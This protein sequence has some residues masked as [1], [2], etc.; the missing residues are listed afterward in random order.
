MLKAD[1]ESKSQRRDDEYEG[2]KRF[3][4]VSK[5]DEFKFD[6]PESLTKCKNDYFNKYVPKKIYKKAFWLKTQSL[7]IFIHPERWMNL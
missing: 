6:I 4:A 3:C 2:F 7:L 5:H 1:R